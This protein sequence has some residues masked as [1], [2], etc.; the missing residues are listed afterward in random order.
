[1]LQL[2]ANELKDVDFIQRAR[3]LAQLRKPEKVLKAAAALWSEYASRCTYGLCPREDLV[4]RR[5]QAADALWKR[6]A[7]EVNTDKAFEVRR[8]H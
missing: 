6:F 2:N 7:T 3:A 8:A 4:E 1:M 5:N